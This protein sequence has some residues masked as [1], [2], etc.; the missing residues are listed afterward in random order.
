MTATIF[1]SIDG[2]A[3]VPAG[4]IEFAAQAG[5]GIT[6]P[7]RTIAA[8]FGGG[9]DIVG[10]DADASGNLYALDVSGSSTTLLQFA[11]GATV[12]K[13]LLPGVA[14]QTFAVDDGGGIY[15]RVYAATES[16]SLEYFPPGSNAPVQ[17]ISGSST[18][19]FAVGAIA[20]P[21]T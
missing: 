2:S 20:V 10:L 18:Q 4:I 1:V 17:I 8:P 21:R 9:H 14:I 19:L 12:G 15:A 13:A 11:P 5:S 6:A 7:I 3:G 16:A